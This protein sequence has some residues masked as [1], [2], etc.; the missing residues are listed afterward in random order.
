MRVRQRAMLDLMASCSSTRS[1]SALPTPLA[2]W[3]QLTRRHV[4]VSESPS[5]PF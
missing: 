2:N 5:E 4:P 3:Q 1:S